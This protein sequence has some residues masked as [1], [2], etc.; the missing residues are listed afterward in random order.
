MAT[1]IGQMAQP[2]RQGAAETFGDIVAAAHV[3]Q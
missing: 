3:G 2:N 1:G